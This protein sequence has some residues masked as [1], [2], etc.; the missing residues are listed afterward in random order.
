MGLSAVIIR[1]IVIMFI[2]ILVGFICAKAGMIDAHTN[3]KMST[4]ALKLINPMLI[5]SSYQVPY[6]ARLVRNLLISFLLAV[7]AY[8]IQIVLGILLI[9]K[10]NNPNYQIERLSMI[11]ANGGYFGIPLIQGLYGAEGTMYL[12]AFITV[13]NLLLWTVGDAVMTGKVNPHSMLKGILTPVTASIVIGLI[14]LFCRIQL[15]ELLMEPIRSIGAMNTPFAMIVAGS[16]LAGTSITACLKQKRTYWVLFL[17]MLLIPTA[18]V[19]CL[20]L[21][22]F[23]ENLVLIP[24]VTAAC[25]IA[26]ACPMFAVLYD[27]D[28]AYSSQI[29]AVSTLLSIVTIPLIFTLG[30]LL[31]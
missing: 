8:I 24:I 15:P 30:G 23:E 5:I 12:T 27:K 4:L 31:V 16:T 26:A 9:R 2:L 18:V 13:F 29:F 22:P 20:S 17:K 6:E 11:F 21:I 19:L 25:P 28:A 10:K 14:L 1:Q 7:I 3:K